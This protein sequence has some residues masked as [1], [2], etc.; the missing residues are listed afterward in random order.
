MSTHYMILTKP[1]DKNIVNNDENQIISLSKNEL[2]FI[3]PKN[4]SSCYLD[5]GLFEAPLIDW[6]KQFCSKNKIT[7]DIGS[8]TGTY[9]ISLS[10]NSKEVYCFEPQKMTYY[11]LCGSVA[12]SNLENIKCLQ[13][14]LGSIEQVGKNKLKIVSNDGGGSSLHATTFL[15]EEEIEI[16]TLDSL[17]IDNIGF[18]K[19]D[20][21][22]NEEYVIRGGIETLRRSNMPTIL[23]ECN[24]KNKNS[25]LFELLISIG[26]K[27]INVSSYN[28]MY[29]AYL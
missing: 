23:F 10:K 26:Y 29:L 15:K 9:G 12:L 22:D 5:N 4:L 3:L 21:E 1:S 28:N 6:S 19:M 17:L 7:L 13:L 20:V 27:I 24:D 18:I 14:G 25:E 8:H 2:C 16:A 11:A